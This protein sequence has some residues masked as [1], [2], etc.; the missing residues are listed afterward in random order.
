MQVLILSIERRGIGFICTRAANAQ[1]IRPYT[2][3]YQRGPENA[4]AAESRG[5]AI[6]GALP[7]HSKARI[8]QKPQLA[9]ARPNGVKTCVSGGSLCHVRDALTRGAAWCSGPLLLNSQQVLVL[10]ALYSRR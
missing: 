3:S 1:L 2:E 4:K 7:H 6:C 5:P 9:P 8:P 10:L